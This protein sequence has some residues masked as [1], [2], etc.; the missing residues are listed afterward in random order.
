MRVEIDVEHLDA[1]AR[2]ATR[3][4]WVFILTGILWILYAFVV[5]SASVATVWAV[6]VL[7]GVG[8][9]AGG[10]V[11]LATAGLANRFRWMHVLFGLV[12]IGAGIVAL[13]WPGQ[14]FIVLAAIVGWYLAIDGILITLVAISTRRE[15]ELWWLALLVGV[16][17]LL[18]GFWAIGYVGR[19]VVLLVVWVAAGALGRGIS[20]LVIGLSLHGADRG[21]RRAL[22]S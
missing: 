12:S 20:S 8:F 2:V 14:T 1:D 5:L 10:I 4:W 7:F 16:A 13:V 15:N 18:V 22:A 6:A 19:S 21:L 3:F 11:E 9:I 17:Q